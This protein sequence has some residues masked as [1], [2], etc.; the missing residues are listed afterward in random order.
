MG[1]W[2]I[3]TCEVINT[4]RVVRVKLYVTRIGYEGRE[5]D[6]W[7]NWAAFILVSF[8]VVIAVIG[9]VVYLRMYRKQ[10]G[11]ATA[12]DNTSTSLPSESSSD[13]EVKQ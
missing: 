1:K 12:Q 8:G 2:S 9:V 4:N 13:P 5:V 7:K 10:A 3:S 11:K 6:L